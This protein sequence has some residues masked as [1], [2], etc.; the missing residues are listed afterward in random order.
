[1]RFSARRVDEAVARMEAAYA[2]ISVDA[3]AIRL[4]QSGQGA[5]W[6]FELLQATGAAGFG[7]ARGR[8]GG[9]SSLPEAGGWASF[10][11]Q[12]QELGRPSDRRQ[13]AT[14]QQLF[15]RWRR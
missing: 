14:L 3:K 13:R 12:E 7:S 4:G 1:M 9:G 15:Q 2:A 6:S 11:C 8:R 5:K 10:A